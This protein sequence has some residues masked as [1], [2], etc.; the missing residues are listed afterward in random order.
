MWVGTATALYAA[1]CAITQRDIKKVL[2]YSTL[3]QLGYMVAAFGLGSLTIQH[4]MGG[5]THSMAIAAGVGAAMF[6]LTT[7]AFFKALMF[8]GSGSVIH[9]CHHEQDIFK[10]GGLKSKMPLTFFTFT[11]GVAAI[12]G[13]P[14][15]AG[16]FSKDAILYLAYENSRAVFVILAF[17]AVLTSLYMV[18]LWKLVFLG[19][20]RS[21]EASHAH[22]GGLSM[23]LPLVVLAALSVVGGY[24][25]VFKKLAGG[26]AILVP[27]AEGSAHSV[28]FA[29]SLA[30]MLLGA[31][32]AL[33]LYKSA[34]ADALQQKSPGLFGLL[35]A[36]KESFDA[37]YDYYVAKIQ[38]RFAML[39]NFFD[40]I[41]LGLI[42]RIGS[43][44]VALVGRGARTLHVGSLHAY[45]YWFLIGAALLWAYAAGAF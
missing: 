11:I 6:H 33:L 43:G 44:L 35:T 27:E 31:G 29:T 30:V 26:I 23:T 15:L 12:I 22:E 41:V 45:V 1:L 10:M 8:L 7:H 13:L 28:I 39:L 36:L 17:T 19:T 2:A 20:P 38:Q 37:I 34:P 9:G 40:Q 16:F 42:I 5:M 24:A 32:A 3:S 14:F 25:G 4:E 18:R 21:D